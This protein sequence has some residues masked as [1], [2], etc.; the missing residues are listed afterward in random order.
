MTSDDSRAKS[1]TSDY[2]ATKAPENAPH[3]TSQPKARDHTLK[4]GGAHG[5]PM[6]IGI[7]D[8]DPERLPGLALD[9]GQEWFGNTRDERPGD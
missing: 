9:P 1:D 8:I 6:G 5:A 4:P 3:V 7:S 2:S